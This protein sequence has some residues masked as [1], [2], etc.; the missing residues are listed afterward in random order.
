ME[1]WTSQYLRDSS[2]KTGRHSQS[3]RAGHVRTNACPHHIVII[4]R[5]CFRLLTLALL[6]FT[7]CALAL[8]FGAC[9]EGKRTGRSVG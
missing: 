3:I 2:Y 1:K 8:L 9:L 6:R 7:L 5:I 4:I